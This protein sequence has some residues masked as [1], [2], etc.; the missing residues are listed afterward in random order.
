MEQEMLEVSDSSPELSQFMDK[1]TL[2]IFCF[3]IQDH[4]LRR[5][6]KP[7]KFF[8]ERVSYS[9]FPIYG[10]RLRE[11]RAYMD[12]QKPKGLRALWRDRR[13]SNTYYTFW[14]VTIFGSL[15]IFL[16]TCGLAVSVAQTW[17]TFHTIQNSN[18]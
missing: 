18:N 3:E 4:L 16:A 14:F 17:A 15:S 7:G 6:S 13:N 11:L 2:S 1:S 12:N 10:D 5:W 8:G 9:Q